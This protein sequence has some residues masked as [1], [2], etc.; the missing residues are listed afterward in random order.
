M[1]PYAH[2]L[3]VG[4][5]DPDSVSPVRSANAGSAETRPFSIEPEAGKIGQHDGQ[6]GLSQS[7]HV[8]SD[9]DGRT[10]LLDDPGVLWP[11]PA[12]VGETSPSSCD[13]EW[14]AWEPPADHID[15]V[16]CSTRHLP[17]VTERPGLR[18]VPMEHRSAVWIYL[19]VPRHRAEPGQLKATLKQAN[20]GEQRADRH[21]C[22]LSARASARLT[23]SA[24]RCRRRAAAVSAGSRTP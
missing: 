22:P 9:D 12:I 14:L 17:D 20:P 11:Q 16:S 24:A 18:P 19:R 23:A 8:L 2:A 7:R 13:A 5:N 10:D 4:S 1:E 6:S 15:S 3:G 21:R